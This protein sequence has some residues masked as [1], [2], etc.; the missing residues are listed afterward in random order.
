[1]W[2]CRTTP[3]GLSDPLPGQTIAKPSRSIARASMTAGPSRPWPPRCPP[4]GLVRQRRERPL[5]LDQSGQR[6]LD[7]G[8]PRHGAQLHRRHQRGPGPDAGR[9]RHDQ[10]HHEALGRGQFADPDNQGHAFAP[11]C[12]PVTTLATSSTA[13][14]G[15]VAI[16]AGSLAINGTTRSAAPDYLRQSGCGAAISTTSRGD[17]HRLGG[18]A[19]T[20]YGGTFNYT[21]NGTGASSET[22]GTLTSTGRG[23]DRPGQRRRGQRHAHLCQHRQRVRQY[24]RYPHFGA[25]S[26]RARTRSS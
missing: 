1:M 4:D 23:H 18:Q 14:A 24:A 6:R 16:N 21:A 11:A 25:S 10:R 19:L 17:R 22:L 9:R 3:A 7:G 12:R 26:A 2:S 15:A 8:R 13:F 5:R 20:L